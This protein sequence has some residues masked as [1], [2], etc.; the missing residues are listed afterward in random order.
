MKPYLAARVF[1]AQR[2][3]HL[4]DRHAEDRPDRNGQKA[5]KRLCVK[6]ERDR[7]ENDRNDD[8]HHRHVGD[9]F[10]R[11]VRPRHA[12]RARRLRILQS[13]IRN[14]ICPAPSIRGLV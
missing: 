12:E 11:R 10:E 1:P 13:A 2:D 14:R 9:P 4:A 6:R 7:S 5:R 8:E 3:Q